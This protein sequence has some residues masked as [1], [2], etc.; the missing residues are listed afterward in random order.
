MT[1]GAN[2]VY[3]T[4]PKGWAAAA[5]EY[6]GLEAEV[7]DPA[8][9]K[10][11]SLYIIDAFDHKW[12]RKPGSIDIMIDAWKSLSG[13]SDLYDS[14]NTKTVEMQVSWKLTGRKSAQWS[15]KGPG[16][17]GG[18]GAGQVVAAPAAGGSSTTLKPSATSAVKT[19]PA[20]KAHESSSVSAKKHWVTSTVSR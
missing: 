13:R 5:S 4:D 18:D 14:S 19:T 2:S 6:C 9:G 1:N 10:T 8:S 17:K 7:T 20:P 12:V 16:S 15:F 11:M 3:S